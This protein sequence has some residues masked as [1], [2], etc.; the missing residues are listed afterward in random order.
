MN[1]DVREQLMNAASLLEKA[2]SLLEYSNNLEKKASATA[3]AMVARGIANAD[4]RK[5]YTD[6]LTQ[7]PE[8]IAS[9]ETTLNSLP[10]AAKNTALG[11]IVGGYDADGGLD[12][13][14]QAVLG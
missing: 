7:N 2:A 4:Q 8:K 9:I 5:F 1:A 6:Y 13:F 10:V 12:P 3:D 14:D 11:D